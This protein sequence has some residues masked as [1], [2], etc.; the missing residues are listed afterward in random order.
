MF[1]LGSVLV[2]LIHSPVTIVMGRLIQGLCTGIYSAIV[3]LYINEIVTPDLSNLGTL[4]QVFIAS[5]QAFSYL[6]YYIMSK[7]T[8]S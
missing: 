7:V 5:S 4:N 3:P 2:L 1:A 6:L 8:D